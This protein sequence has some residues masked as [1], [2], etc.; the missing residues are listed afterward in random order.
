M[1]MKK[2]LVAVVA[3]AMLLMMWFTACGEIKQPER[4]GD[5]VVLYTND[6]HCGVD[7][8]IGYSGLAALEKKYSADGSYV[9][10]A[11]CGDALQGAPVG[12]LSKGE[13]IID[14]M[15]EIGYDVATIGNHEF[16]YGSERFLELAQKAN[17][18][19]VSCN[20]RNIES[21]EIVFDAYKII[22][23]DGIKI[24]FVGICTPHTITSSA[25]AYFQ[26]EQ[27]EF[28]YAFDQDKDGTLLYN[29]VQRAVDDA[30]A[31]GADYVI[32]L[33]HLGITADALP[34]T[35]SEVIQNTSGIDVMLDGHSHSVVECER[36][37][38]KDGEWVLLSQT[39]TKFES[40]GMLLIEED[41]SVS[42]G[43]ISGYEEKDAHMAAFIGDIQSEFEE[44]LQTVVAKTSVDLIVNDPA[45]GERI[46]RNNETN[47]GD[48]CAD[49]Y[50]IMTGADIGFTNGGGIRA[51]IKKGEITYEDILTVHPFG[52]A[53]CVVEATGQEILDAL[54]LG[55]RAYPEEDGSFMHVSGISF[56]I[57]SSVASSVK[58]T[59]DGMFEAVEGEYRVK[60]VMVGN[61]ALQLDKTYTLA[62][63]DYYLK[64]AGGGFVMFLD[65]VMIQDSIMLDNQIL[66]NYIVDHLNG[67]V[68]AEYASPYGQ[69]RIVIK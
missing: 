30:K 12:T 3:F 15:N 1:I 29:S 27:G 14:I 17:F 38:N 49:A 61:E 52:N 53:V 39:G 56:E 5:I 47:L 7:D 42:T 64:N 33:A 62:C 6:V 36:V 20:F 24:A 34:W 16:D 48:L 66:I 51:D 69:E 57:H 46:V 68:G 4:T 8:S 44:E 50:R 54:E 41:G 35:S 59:E 40:V 60:N 45:T 9:I 37:K 31:E 2:K 58:L 43:L 18:P 25:P 13:Y 63:H 21:G 10:L 23:V 28:M 67:E 32:A 65:N 26:N 55:A 22:E 19:Y 11:D